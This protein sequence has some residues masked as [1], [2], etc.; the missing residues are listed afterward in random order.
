MYPP[1]E[2]RQRLAHPV[3]TAGDRVYAIS[4]QNGLF[5]DSWGGHVP[6]EMWGIWDHPIKLFD[7]FWLGVRVAGA[8]ATHW[9]IEADACRVGPGWTEFDYR[10]GPL[11]V[12]RRDCVPD[13]VEGMVVDLTVRGAGEAGAEL[14]LIVLLRSDLRPAWLGE[15][16]GMHDGRETARVDGQRG[17]VVFNDTDNPWTAVAGAALPLR[18][19]QIGDDLWAVQQTA[20]QG[21][22]A[23]LT[24]PLLIDAASEARLTLFLA[25]SATSEAAACTTYE[26]LRAEHTALSAAK[27]ERLQTIAETSRVTTPDTLVDEALHWAKLNCQMLARNV[28]PYGLGAGAGLPAYAWWFGID[29]AYATLPMLQAGL[30]ELARA[31]LDLLK[32][33]SVETNTDEPGRVIH[34]LTTTGV[35]FNPGNLVETPAFTRA[36][37][38]YW[39]WTGD[40]AWLQEMYPFCKQGLLDYTLGRNDPDGDLCPSGRSIIETLEMHAGFECI[41]VASYTWEALIRL[42][43]MAPAAGD[44]DA[45]PDLLQKAHVLG[46]RLREEWWIE[47]EGLFADVRASPR[48]VRNALPHIESW[49]LKAGIHPDVRRQVE[50]ARQRFAPLLAAR[51]GAAADVDL[52]WLL[53]HWVVLCPVEVGLATPEQAARVLDRLQSPEFSNEWG[54]CLHPDRRITMSISAGMLGL[55][56]ARYGDTAAA[57]RVVRRLADSLAHHMPGAISEALPDR[58]CC[59]QLWSALGVI[60]PV[61]EG[62]L[63]IAPRAAE[64]RLRVVP[65][66]PD[67]WDRIAAR[68][69]RVGGA[70]F[71]VVVERGVA[72][73]SV[74]VAGDAPEYRIEAGCYPPEGITVRDVSWNGADVEWHWETTTGGRCVVCETEGNGTVQVRYA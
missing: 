24:Y 68:R 6:A 52:P 32:R 31:T 41:D 40:R 3:V 21:A 62:F 73:Y 1:A 67:G 47:P 53:R 70:L 49:A 71:D 26:R 17:C 30:F 18:D 29:S 37:H 8:P 4:S 61:V 19:A 34:E 42:A 50:Q 65:N 16:A 10:S 64:R 69:L 72:S 20:G 5:P 46:R 55:A 35:V 45:V 22:S 74:Q 36:V 60:A 13:G 28:P 38:H 7:G 23:R 63:G 56:A 39:L 48:E 15:Q 12:V 2:K 59:V 11:T 25:G 14:E 33:V 57:L 66:L 51:A 27:A 58:W 44:A 43:D 9:L 54:L